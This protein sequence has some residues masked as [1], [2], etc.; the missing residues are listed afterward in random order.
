MLLGE[1]FIG[2][3]PVFPTIA[4]LQLDLDANFRLYQ[5]VSQTVPVIVQNDPVASWKDKSLVGNDVSQT[6]SAKRPKFDVNTVN[7]SPS[8]SFDG[9]LQY[10]YRSVG[11]KTYTQGAV[12]IVFDRTSTS[13]TRQVFEG[14]QVANGTPILFDAQLPDGMTPSVLARDDAGNLENFNSTSSVG[15]GF[16]ILFGIIWSTSTQKLSMRVNGVQVNTGTVALGST[17]VDIYA[18]GSNGN[19]LG[20]NLFQGDIARLLLYDTTPSAE[21]IT[22][23]ENELNLLYRLY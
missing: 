4:G 18:V 10:L 23:I 11:A 6:V 3:A 8:V 7:G 16:F 12:W 2:R 17:T 21:D 14:R 13:G 1:R 22:L 20:A 9:S 19:S 15:S 5:N